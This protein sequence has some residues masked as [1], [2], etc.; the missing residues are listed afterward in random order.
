MGNGSLTRFSEPIPRKGTETE[1]SDLEQQLQR[2]VFQNLFPARG[3][4]LTAVDA[5]ME[6]HWFYRFSEPIPRK[7]TETIHLPPQLPRSQHPCFSEPI[8][9]KGTETQVDWLQLGV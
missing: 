6:L 2:G 8:P 3:R 5:G 7:G 9:R 1:L 4:K